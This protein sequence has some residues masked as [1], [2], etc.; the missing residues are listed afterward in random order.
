MTLRNS[1]TCDGTITIAYPV[2]V[3]RLLI[4]ILCASMLPLTV[5]AQETTTDTPVAVAPANTTLIDTRVRKSKLPA[6]TGVMALGADGQPIWKSR[7][8][9][10]FIPAST[11][12]LITAIVALEVMGK[13]WKPVTSVRYDADSGTMY[14]VASG[15]PLITSGQLRTLAYKVAN[16]L[17]TFEEP[18]TALRV[19]D[20]LFPAPTVAPG[21]A[22]AQQPQELNPV[23]ALMVD[24]RIGM[25]S[26]A[27]GAKIF[28][29]SLKAA[30]VHVE[31]KGRGTAKGE[32][33]AALAGTRLQGS[34]RTMLWYSDN[35]IAEMIFRLSALAAGRSAT[36]ADARL[37]AYE[38]L[39]RLGVPTKDV[40]LIDGS[41]LSR[42]N[43]LSAHVLTEV[44]RVAETNERTSVLRALL[45]TAGVEGTIRTRFR[46][47]PAACV[48]DALKAKTGG[49]RDVVSLAGYAPLPD[50]TYRPFAIIANGISGYSQG[51]RVRRAIDALAASFS[52]C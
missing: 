48:K 37:T 33:V 19:D 21:V 15:D 40:V 45:P 47:E 3:R 20:S 51:N 1:P 12:K 36:W 38:Q 31:Y 9:E 46:T 28:N 25:D 4:A 8:Y 49:L 44:L 22:A 34:L 7:A 35:D 10:Q 5:S 17:A 32:E 41:G 18:P 23:R 11:M 27:M 39:T 14:L 50:G 30:G 42:K 29:E 43:R 52:G 2:P 6:R 13:D 16:A 24:R 26:S